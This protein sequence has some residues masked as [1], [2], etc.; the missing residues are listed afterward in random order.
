MILP[1]RQTAICCNIIILV[2]TA[3]NL[4]VKVYSK[5]TLFDYKKKVYITE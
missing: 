2:V 3:K 5:R 1:S 4:S